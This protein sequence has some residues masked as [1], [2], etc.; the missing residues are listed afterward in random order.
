[1][2]GLI[3]FYMD[4][5]ELTPVPFG[6]RVM[7]T[8]RPL[9]VFEQNNSVGYTL[10]FNSN[11]PANT[12]LR[13]VIKDFWT[14]EVLSS[15]FKVKE[16][17]RSYQLNFGRFEPGW[18]TLEVYD[19]STRMGYS[20]FSVVAPKSARKKYED[21][22]FAM[23]FGSSQLVAGGIDAV[24]EYIEAAELTGIQWVRERYLWQEIEPQKGQWLLEPLD[25]DL[26]P[27]KT[28]A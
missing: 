1:M 16:G 19:G 13:F 3:I 2:D 26:A 18:Y 15:D 5:F 17:S 9:N 22:P 23:D 6:I 4:Y 25:E 28:R 24:K 11:A 27:F 20:T 14:A 7:E 21:T 10:R 12:E 8:D